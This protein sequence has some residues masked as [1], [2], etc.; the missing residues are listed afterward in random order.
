MF[1]KDF[2][3]AGQPLNDV[4]V[5]DAH[6]HAGDYVTRRNMDGFISRMDHFGIDLSCIS[7]TSAICTGM[8]EGN[9]IVAEAVGRFPDRFIGVFVF[10]PVRP[11]KSLSELK[12]AFSAGWA[13][14]IKIHPGASRQH[15]ASD[16]Y[17]PMWEVAE[18]NNVFVLCHTWYN[19]ST[20]A[21][22]HFIEISERYPNVPVLLGHSGGLYGGYK[23]AMAAVTKKKNLFMELSSAE[24][25]SMWLQQ[26][27]ETVGAENLVF[28]TDFTLLD[29]AFSLG[30][31]A[32]ARISEADKKRILGEN[33]LGI[34]SNES[35]KNWKIRILNKLKQEETCK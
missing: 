15:V 13:R 11:G 9:D 17:R 25:S 14:G 23:E 27:V 33:M 19:K 30:R 8:T 6:S 35:S 3:S 34:L 20:H 5:I 16:G 29:Q 1:I 31:V 10:D 24:F 21:P 32:Y 7:S 28:G 12:R 26:V 2:V 22:H 18:E 4:L